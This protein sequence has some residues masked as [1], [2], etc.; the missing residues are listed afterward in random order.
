VSGLVDLDIAASVGRE[1]LGLGDLDLNDYENYIL[2]RGVRVGAVSWRRDNVTSPYVHG[3]IPVHEVMDAAESS[4][5]VYVLG[6]THG[7]LNA[8]LGALLTAFTQQYA[9][10]LGLNV[11]GVNYQW[12]CDRAD[13]EIGFA[14]E[15]LVARFLPVKFTFYRHPIPLVGVF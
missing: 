9:Y 11:E 6:E 14:T 12:R 7:A 15:T 5:D 8:N 1:E 3:H 4:I 13:F 10:V 2:G